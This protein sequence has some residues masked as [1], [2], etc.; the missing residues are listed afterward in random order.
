MVIHKQR[1]K[2][3]KEEQGKRRL[4]RDEPRGEYPRLGLRVDEIRVRFKDP[5]RLWIL[6]SQDVEIAD[7]PRADNTHYL[8]K[9]TQTISYVRAQGVACFSLTM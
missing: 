1:R 8:Y 7:F 2:V 3:M 6:E 4:D 9:R 5:W